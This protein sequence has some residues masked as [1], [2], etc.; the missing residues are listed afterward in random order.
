M[1]ALKRTQWLASTVLVLTALLLAGLFGRVVWIQKHVTA[2]TRD[3]LSR[4]YTAV[5]PLMAQRQAILFADSTPAALSVRMYNMFADPGF[6]M[7][8]EGK[9]NPLEGD[10]VEEAR[11]VLTEALAPLVE[12]SPQELEFELEK[13]ATYANGKPRRFLWLKREVD[14][15]FFNKFVELKARL[16]EESRDVAKSEQH[17]KDG[18]A[19]AEAAARAKILFHALDGVGFVK[20]MKRVYP[21]GTLGGSIIGYASQYE[22]VDG[23]EHQLNDLLKGIPGQMY[24]T[25]DARRQTLLVQDQRFTA[26]DDG[27]AVW[28]TINSV[29]QG[30]AEQ[31][32]KQAVDEHGAKRG[33]AIVLDPHSG[34][35]LA[36]ANYPFFDPAE[37]GSADPDTRRNRAV[38][39]PYEPGS[40]F[41]PFI[42]GW[43]IEKHIVKPSDVFDCRQGAYIDPT[44]RLVRDTHGVGVATVTDILVKSSNIGMTQIGWKMGIPTMYEAVTKFGFGKRTGVELPGDQA[45]IVKPLAKW[46]KGTLT[47]ASFGYEVAAT[48]LQL[49]RAFA[50]FANGGYL[51]TPRVINAVEDTPGHAVPWTD[52]GRL[53]VQQQIVSAQ[54]AQTM[55]DMMAEVLGPRG[56]AKSAASKIYTMYGKTGTAHVAAGAHG[57]EGRGY[58]DS[59][60]DSSFLVGGPNASPRLVAIVTLHKP[61][62]RKGYYGGTVAAPAAVAIMERS[63]MYLQ[64]PSDMPAAPAKPEKPDAR[65]VVASH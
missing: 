34:R 62:L 15:S 24:V 48:P 36:L 19:R 29:L 47:S 44:G 30:I 55:R 32:L 23:M 18:A 1:D 25:K 22:G 9:L 12:K 50:T 37:F 10:D 5:I 21:M 31:Q 8:P 45:G 33:T 6:I 57:T 11:K 46:N 40:I 20:S 51:V 16:K 17:N 3:R 43:A 27:R 28:L 59:D 58:G 38:T 7:D 42:L 13:N 4:Q 60:Y 53:P 14:E 54:T 41:K 35:I 63:L 56:T 52:V 39:D 2:E 64:V 49:V 65:R 26:A 61:D